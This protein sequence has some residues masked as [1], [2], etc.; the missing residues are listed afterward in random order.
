VVFAQFYGH[1][2]KSCIT[3]LWLC[4]SRRY[5]HGRSPC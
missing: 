4:T 2:L 3:W 1:R 5:L